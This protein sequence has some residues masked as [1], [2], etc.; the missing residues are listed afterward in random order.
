[1]LTPTAVYP[2]LLRWV[3]ALDMTPSAVT[4][5]ALAARVTALWCGQS[6]A[7][8]S[9]MRMLPSPTMV[10][11]RARY[12]RVA[13]TWHGPWLTSVWLTPLL[14]RAALALARPAG[15]PV[16]VL[17]TV[18][19]GRWELITIGLLWHRRVALVGWAVL[20][21]PWPKGRF[22]PTVI[23]LLRQV[24]ATWPEARAAPHL[25][26]DRGFPSRPFFQTLHDLRW[27]YTVRL[28]AGCRVTLHGAAIRVGD[29]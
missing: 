1:M 9:L 6:L 13:R 28:S 7:P 24:G 29:L 2:R 12:A 16:L 19:C 18:R 26:A 20:P 14:V 5:Q 25:L 10:R 11:A 21:Y 8:A 23:A 3:Q 22:T 17:D 4:A 15:T 27:G